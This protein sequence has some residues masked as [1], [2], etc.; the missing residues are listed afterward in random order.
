M[1]CYIIVWLIIFLQT[2][3]WKTEKQKKNTFV[4]NWPSFLNCDQEIVPVF[5]WFK[6]N[7]VYPHLY[8]GNLLTKFMSC[9]HYLSL[10]Q[11]L[12]L[13]HT[14]A[15]QLDPFVH[16]PPLYKWV[17]RPQKSWRISLHADNLYKIIQDPY[18][19]VIESLIW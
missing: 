10:H 2:L 13:P 16:P 3:S 5:S 15:F 6:I 18:T 19:H 1:L 14:G 11:D 7:L 4:C 8:R 9:V 17:K 12:L